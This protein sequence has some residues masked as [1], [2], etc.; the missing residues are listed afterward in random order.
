MKKSDFIVRVAQK[1]D[2]DRV[3]ALCAEHAAFEQSHYDPTNKKTRLET[4][5]FAPIAKLHCIVAEENEHILGF[6]TYMLQYST[7]EACEYV[8]LDCIY[9][10]EMAR[11][12]GIGQK[13]MQRVQREAKK[14]NCNLI[15]WQT[16]DFN[17]SAIAFYKK[18]GA[19]SKSKERFFL[20]I[21]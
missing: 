1:D 16:P 4:D 2:L 15:Q 18:I 3:V 7:W 20:G 11:R 21:G 12:K 19:T 17:Y 5:L 13:L 6:A 8:Y 14:L 10:V 9:L